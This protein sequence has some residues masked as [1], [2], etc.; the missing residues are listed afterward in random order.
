MLYKEQRDIS[1]QPNT[2]MKTFRIDLPYTPEK[3]KLG[4]ISFKLEGEPPHVQ[5]LVIKID[6]GAEH[7]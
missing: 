5:T 7:D 1:H 6:D 3:Y 4:E 2:T